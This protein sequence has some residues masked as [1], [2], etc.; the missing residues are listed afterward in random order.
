MKRIKISSLLPLFLLALFS[1]CTEEWDNH[2]TINEESV[3]V[4]LWD[5]LKSMNEYSE[6]IKYIE[7][8]HFDTIIKSPITKTL[9][10]PDNEAFLEYTSKDTTGLR[11]TLAYHIMPTFF[12]LRNI[13]TNQQKRVETY[14][15]KFAL[16]ENMNGTFYFDGI[17]ISKSSPAFQDGKFY[18]IGKVINPKPNLYENLKWNNP[19]IYRYIN[20]QDSI[21]LD[22]EKS[23]PYGFNE[24]GETVYSDS[25]TSIINLFEEEY[26][27]IS[28]EFRTISATLVI[29]D[30]SSYENAL[31]NMCLSL[32]GS[33]KSHEDIPE[34]WQNDILIPALL[35]KGT[36]GGFL[37][38]SDFSKKIIVNILGDTLYRDFEINPE[39]L[40]ICSNGWIYSYATFSVGDSLYRRN[41]L[42][43]ERLVQSL[44]SN[45]YIWI[46]KGVKVE[47][48]VNFQPKKQEIKGASNDSVVNVKFDKNFNGDYAVTFTMK[49]V[50]PKKYRLV[51]RTQYLNSGVFSIYVNGEKIPLGLFQVEDFDTYSIL[52]DD[53]FYSAKGFITGEYI[54]NYPDSRGFCDVDGYVENLSQYGNVTIKIEYQG[55]GQGPSFGTD[56]GLSI[57]YIGLLPAPELD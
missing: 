36:Y 32:G 35:Y 52:M 33:F 50:F 46:D 17:E 4:K 57:D 48:N 12:M 39:S 49:N 22:R 55:P 25:V 16:I 44:G 37:Y 13:G 53:G 1:A 19:A 15:K 28:E 42:E 5:T 18:E 41:I 40:S 3:N 7:L 54:K 26:F 34:E 51:W 21:I 11:E 2:F 6:F 47:G 31:D 45:R 30:K 9:F 24:S 56:N 14:F 27:P 10:I 43:P 23:T 8:T 38:A 29:P 20:L